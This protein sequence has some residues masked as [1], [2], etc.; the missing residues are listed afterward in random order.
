[1]VII[2]F[3]TFYF[4]FTQSKE[5]KKIEPNSQKTKEVTLENNNAVS[6][7]LF[8]GNGSR[9]PY[10]FNQTFMHM[11]RKYSFEPKICSRPI[12]GVVTTLNINS[13][14]IQEIAAHFPV[15]VVGDS[16]TFPYNHENLVENAN[17][18]FLDVDFQ[19]QMYPDFSR[20]LPLNNFARKNIGY[21][22][23]LTILKACQILDFDD[24]NCLGEQAKLSLLNSNANKKILWAQS[25]DRVV[26][27]YLLYGASTFIWPR[28]YP[29][30][31]ISKKTWPSFLSTFPNKDAEYEVDVLQFMQDV[32]PDVDAMWRLTNSQHHLPMKWAPMETLSE[33]W[34][35][36][37]PLSLSPF[38]AQSTLL[39]RRIA[40]FSYLPCTVHG[41][42]SDIW[43]SFVMQIM[44][45]NMSPKPGILAFSGD[46]FIHQRNYH[47]YLADFDGEHQL[48]EQTR[49]FIEFIIKQKEYIFNDNNGTLQKQNPMLTWLNV[50]NELYT[51]GFIELSDVIGAEMWCQ[52]LFSETAVILDL[53]TEVSI[54]NK[55]NI[56]VQ[57]HYWHHDIACVLHINHH[58]V[59]NLPVWMAM[60]AWKFKD[61]SMIKVYVPG[62][63]PCSG[64]SGIPVYCISDDSGGH[65]A[66]ESVIHTIDNWKDSIH[67]G[68]LFTHDDGVWRTLLG[69]DLAKSF[70]SEI[71]LAAEAWLAETFFKGLE[72]LPKIEHE[73]AYS[74]GSSERK[75][76]AGQSDIFYL[77]KQH[78]N[79]FQ[80]FAKI[81]RKHSLFLEIAVP[82]IFKLL[83]EKTDVECYDTLKLFT[84]WAHDRYDTTYFLE[85][86]CV[87]PYDLV[88]PLKLSKGIESHLQCSYSAVS[89]I[90]DLNYGIQA[91]RVFDR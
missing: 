39:S 5:K 33:Y 75:V 24:D 79:T 13:L 61:T 62:L 3:L 52:H 91:Q 90:Q 22:H 8:T 72:V 29:L 1:M 9:I 71:V 12:V 51:R 60:H 77:T 4:I 7:F 20:H 2:Y 28:G 49:A 41:R 25:Q 38:N 68:I 64:L 23:A 67:N 17:L 65:F 86:G 18:L 47:N 84:T 85:N 63:S 50:M 37:H 19:N 46:M 43:R 44:T 58:H 76:W 53:E 88:H 32:D 55:P 82:I 6:G 45:L 15:V 48:Y 78:F 40:M 35:G 59:R 36:I 21:L 69:L 26:N 83:Y 70:T 14:C 34:I 57:H 27:P 42:V 66:Y 74:M 30:D 80:S 54:Q 31:S 87:D 89:P 16:K 73:T 56:W 81:M 11:L 10:A